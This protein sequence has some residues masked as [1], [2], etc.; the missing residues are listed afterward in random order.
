VLAGVLE[1]ALVKEAI[2]M[3]QEFKRMRKFGDTKPEIISAGTTRKKQ[4]RV[5]DIPHDINWQNWQPQNRLQERVKVWIQPTDKEMEL[6]G[7]RLEQVAL[8]IEPQEREQNV[9]LYKKNMDD[10][11][12]TIA[13]YIHIQFKRFNGEFL[14]DENVNWY[15]GQLRR[16][17]DCF[18]KMK[19]PGHKC[20][21]FFSSLFYTRMT[22]DRVTNLDS[23]K[24]WGGREKE[25]GKRKEKGIYSTLQF[26]DL[27]PCESSI[28]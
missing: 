4:K 3:P 18:R 26:S 21:L 27:H 5:V 25:N 12:C 16:R 11:E 6:A 20:C 22:G 14:S 17:D 8:P 13:T 2:V 1:A 7:K 9:D 19:T 10:C 24:R 15:M 28:C 23:L